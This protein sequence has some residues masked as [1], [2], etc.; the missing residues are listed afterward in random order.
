MSEPVG[1]A[2]GLFSQAEAGARATIIVIGS[3]LMAFIVGGV[4]MSG[5]AARLA[6]RLGT[7]EAPLAAF[8][9]G[10]LLQRVWLWLVLPAIGWTAGRLLTVNPWNFALVAGLTGEAF[11]ALLTTATGGVEMLFLG[12][13]DVA[14]R[15]LTLAAGLWLTSWATE[16]GRAAA[17]A[18][19]EVASVLTAAQK[20]EY[21]AFL[22]RAEQGPAATK[23]G[24][25]DKPA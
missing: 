16:Q 25:G 4:V 19:Q 17:Q 24:D 12:W 13:A 8:I 21:A 14:A 1:K 2:P 5:L 7:I 15:L 18:A 10:W 6:D 20:A 23:P 22:A 9:V 11:G 3:G